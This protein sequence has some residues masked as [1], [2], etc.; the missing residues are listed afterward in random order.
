M[1]PTKKSCGCDY[2][3]D[4]MGKMRCTNTNRELTVF[5]QPEGWF[6]DLCYHDFLCPTP[7]V[8]NVDQLINRINKFAA[9]MYTQIK[10]EEKKNNKRRD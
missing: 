8:S 5:D 10:G 4:E 3:Y 6:C 7:K 9:M 1:E 2:V